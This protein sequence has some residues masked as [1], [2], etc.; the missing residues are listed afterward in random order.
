MTVTDVDEFDVTTPVDGN[1][2]ADSVAENSANGTLVGLTAGATDGDATTSGVSYALT[3]DAGGRFAIDVNTGVV[4][5]ADGSLLDRE[6]AASYAITVRATSQ[7]GSTADTIFTIALG[8]VDEF[9]VTTPVDGN[10]AADSVAENAAKRHAR[11][12][13]GH[14]QRRRRDDQRC[15]LLAHRQRRRALLDRCQHRHGHRR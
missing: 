13:H 3:D 2:A 5:V 1:A 15:E 12:H 10:A 4:T 14:C 7:D 9:D 11:R 6:A 8:D